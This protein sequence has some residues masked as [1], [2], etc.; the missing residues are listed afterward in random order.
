MVFTSFDYLI[1]LT[2]VF[3]IYWLIRFKSAQNLIL[4]TASYIFY[5]Y[6]HHWFCLLIAVSTFTDYFCGLGM[7]KFQKHKKSLLILSLLVN[8]GML[9]TFKYFNFFAENF[10]AL[11]LQIGLD[12]H[13]ITFKIFLP[14]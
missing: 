12:F 8:L 10:Q 1:F 3:A 14:L 6:V 9:G 5:G 11:M 4:L 2:S 13:P 7:V